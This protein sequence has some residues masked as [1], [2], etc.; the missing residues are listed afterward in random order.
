MIYR[1]YLKIKSYGIMF[2]L[3]FIVNKVAKCQRSFKFKILLIIYSAKK[4][5]DLTLI[6]LNVSAH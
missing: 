1:N 5:I 3:S 2:Y 6:L 4:F